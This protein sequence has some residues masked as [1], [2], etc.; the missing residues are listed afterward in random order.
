MRATPSP[1]TVI[2]QHVS[3]LPI[4][5]AELAR[6]LALSMPANMKVLALKIGGIPRYRSSEKRIPVQ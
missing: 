4:L 5:N 1:P 6:W 2:T 3:I